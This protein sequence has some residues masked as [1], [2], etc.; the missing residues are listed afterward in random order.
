MLLNLV[1]YNLFNFYFDIRPFVFYFQ[2]EDRKGPDKNNYGRNEKNVGISIHLRL[3]L[4]ES[5]ELPDN[6]RVVCAYGTE[7]VYF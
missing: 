1:I 2:P 5:D 4:Y 6:C 3:E 7:M